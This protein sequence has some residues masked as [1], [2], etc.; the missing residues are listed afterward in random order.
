MILGEYALFVKETFISSRFISKRFGLFLKQCEIIGVSSSGIVVVAG[1]FMGAV[2][3]YQLYVSFHF[4]GAE[5]LLGGSVGVSLFRE[6]GPVMTAI[7]VTGRAGAAMA[8]EISSMRISEQIDAMEVMAVD[9]IEY[10]V[11]PRVLAGIVML[12]LLSVFFCAVA[13]IAASVIA[14]Q[15]MGL[16]SSVFWFQYS[17]VVDTMELIHCV[18]KGIMFGFVLTSIGCFCG[19]RAQG[20]ALAVGRATRNTVVATCLT[21]LLS[22]YILTSLLPFGFKKLTVAS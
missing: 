17:K 10:L 2:L 22:D 19:Y 6:L 20:G 3:G 1:L 16:D 8:A 13:T 7:M 4:F 21:I 5:A 12:P 9:P 18:T 15:V 11:T 14:C